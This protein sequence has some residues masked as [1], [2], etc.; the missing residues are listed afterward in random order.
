M[1]VQ[2]PPRAPKTTVERLSFFA[3]AWTQK[4]PTKG[5]HGSPA[6][7]VAWGK[8]EQR[9]EQALQERQGARYAACEDA[10]SPRAP[11]DRLMPVVF[12]AGKRT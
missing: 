5:P 4:P 10:V 3:Q 8:D 6:K 1:R 11:N 7:R 2:V 9:N 12:G